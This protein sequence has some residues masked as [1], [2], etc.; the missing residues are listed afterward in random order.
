MVE[1]F[2][3][4][5]AAALTVVISQQKGYDFFV[6]LIAGF[7]CPVIALPWACLM[8]AKPNSFWAR[9]KGSEAGMRKCPHCA[10]LIKEEARLCRFCGSAS[11]PTLE[12]ES[13]PLET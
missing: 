6:W 13:V 12:A 11:S 4:L 5:I 9:R 2:L 3:Y 8:K 1:L 7:L 10:E